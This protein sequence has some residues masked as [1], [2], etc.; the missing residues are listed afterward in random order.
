METKWWL[1]LAQSPDE[2]EETLTS[3]TDDDELGARLILYNDD[4]HTFDFVI[5]CLQNV[6]GLE[7]HQAEQLTLLVH[8]KG[9]ATCKRGSREKLDEMCGKLVGKGLDAEVK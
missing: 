3:I 2:E 1:W 6:C 4:Y 8:Y 7:L 5:E 9:K